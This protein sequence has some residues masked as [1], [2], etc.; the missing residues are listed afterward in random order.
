MAIRL[1]KEYGHDVIPVHPIH[2]SI[3]GLSVRATL[4]DVEPRSVDTV[5]VY[6]NPERST[7]Q[8]DLLLAL[9]PQRVI[10]NPGAE[11]KSLQE[12]LEEADIDVENGCTMV[13]L[14]TGAF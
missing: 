12:A 11:N 13:L 2:H 4:A 1:L 7:K 14:R 10:F 9:Q 8:K 5:T 6:M 3:E